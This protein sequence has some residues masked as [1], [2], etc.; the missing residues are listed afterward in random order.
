MRVLKIQANRPLLL[1]TMAVQG[2]L[3]GILGRFHGV[4][5]NV[6]EVPEYSIEERVIS[7]YFSHAPET[8]H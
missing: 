1:S 8:N 3:L 6:A 7:L 2:F 5:E 4:Q